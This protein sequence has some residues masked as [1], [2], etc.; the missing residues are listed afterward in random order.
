METVEQITFSGD[1]AAQKGQKEMFITER[2]LLGGG[3]EGMMITE[4]A[5]GV[6][7]ER[8]IL[9]QMNFKPIVSPRLRVMDPRIF[10]EGLMGLASSGT[11]GKS[12]L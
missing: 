11:P 10:Q 7:M 1:Y 8:Q 4:I 3:R 6:E 5:P 2:A 9:S 12:S